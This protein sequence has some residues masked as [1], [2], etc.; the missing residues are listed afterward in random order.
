[1]LRPV[2]ALLSSTLIS[3]FTASTVKVQPHPSCP[4][5]APECTVRTYYVA[6]DEQ[7]WDYAPSGM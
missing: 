2:I 6:A 4:N 3:Q 1:M 7:E 5:N